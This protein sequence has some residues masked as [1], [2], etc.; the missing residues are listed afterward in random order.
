VADVRIASQQLV[1]PPTDIDVSENVV[2]TLRKV[3]HNSGPYGPV[4]VSISATASAPPDCTAAPGAGNPTSARLPVSA[5]VVIDETW[6]IHCDARSQ[7]VFS[8]DNQITTEDPGVIDP[9]LGNNFASAQLT[10][11]V[12]DL[13]DLNMLDQDVDYPLDGST[14]PAGENVEVMVLTV[15]R[16]DGPFGPVDAVAQTDV[17][18][19]GVCQVSPPDGHT[20][21]IWGLPV[22]VNV[23]LKAPFTIWCEPG[24]H[25]FSFHNEIRIDMLHVRDPEDVNNDADTY[26]TVTAS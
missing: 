20:E 7:H 15:I 24:Q 19:P 12:W 3:L 16:N 9:N 2:V 13:A 21:Q 8:F 18:W 1:G 22:G 4:D 14:I 10:V 11:D 25:T 5:N 6:T 23:T 17:T 26:L